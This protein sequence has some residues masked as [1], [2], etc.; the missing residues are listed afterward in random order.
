[1]PARDAL[2]TSLVLIELLQA[3]PRKRFVT[4]V[5]LTH[6][7]ASSGYERSLRSVQRLLEQLADHFPIECDTRSKP[8]RYRWRGAGVTSL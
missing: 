6:T 5:Q 3:I 8:Y 4:A 1:M 7:L 2:D